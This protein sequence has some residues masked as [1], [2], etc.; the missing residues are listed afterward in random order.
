MQISHFSLLQSNYVTIISFFSLLN[1][2][3]E[4]GNLNQANRSQRRHLLI[5]TKKSREDEE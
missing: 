1:L 3:C 5:V 2:S 4:I